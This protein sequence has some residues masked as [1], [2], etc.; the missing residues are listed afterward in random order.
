MEKKVTCEWSRRLAGGGVV[1]GLS[2]L[3]LLCCW[4]KKRARTEFSLQMREKQQDQM[5]LNMKILII[6]KGIMVIS[7][8]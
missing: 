8:K 1:V 6:M 3:D 5:R 7:S 2:G 4:E